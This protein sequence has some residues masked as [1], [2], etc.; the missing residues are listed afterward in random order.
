MKIWANLFLLIFF[1]INSLYADGPL[2]KG[3][4]NALIEEMAQHNLELASQEVDSGGRSSYVQAFAEFERTGYLFFSDSDYYG[5]AK[6]IK[7]TLAKNLPSDVKLV[8][9]TQSKNKGFLN[10]LFDTYKRHIDEQQLIILQLPRSGSNDFWTRDNLPIP[11]WKD[12]G[13]GLVDAQ[14]YYNFE[15]DLF[16]SNIFNADYAKHRYF[17]EGGNFI[18]NSKGDCIVVNRKKRYSGGTSDTAAI[19]DSIFKNKY[20]CQNLIRLKHLKGIGHSDEVVKFM[21][22]NLIVTDEESYIPLLEAQGFTVKL[23]PEPDRN[24]E[25]YINSLQVNDILYVPTFGERHDQKAIDAYKSLNLGLK[26]VPINTR[27]LA[28]RGQGG[29]HCITMNYPNVPMNDLAREF[30]ANVLTYKDFQ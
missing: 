1:S 27:Q 5:M 26:I 20:G 8:V 3:P 30:N 9:Y 11:V 25:T 6:K 28:T 18:A 2:P 16:I 21:T 10:R 24:Y 15:P 13:F 23:L 17:F 7:E 14:Y 19:P 12:G 22:D 29:I 4:S